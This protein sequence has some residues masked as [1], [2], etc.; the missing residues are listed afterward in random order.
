[1]EMF[2]LAKRQ[3]SPNLTPVRNEQ[4]ILSRSSL[5][6]Q[7]GGLIAQGAFGGRLAVMDGGE[8]FEDTTSIPF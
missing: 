1:M 5:K 2:S 8:P 3:S 7:V 4:T 6:C